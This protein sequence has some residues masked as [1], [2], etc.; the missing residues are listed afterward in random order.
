MANYYVSKYPQSDGEH[1]VHSE[2][3]VL[4]PEKKER[5][6]LGG[7]TSSKQAVKK[8]RVYYAR[9]KACEYCSA[10]VPGGLI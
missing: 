8:A 6:Y 9:A 2:H 10:K 4:L 5:V 1:E 3:C 7:F